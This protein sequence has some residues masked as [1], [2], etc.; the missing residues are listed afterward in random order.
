MAFPP[1]GFGEIVVTYES[2]DGSVTGIRQKIFMSSTFES[3]F[4]RALEGA[5]RRLKDRVIG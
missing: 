3:E 1:T 5:T 4:N 2:V